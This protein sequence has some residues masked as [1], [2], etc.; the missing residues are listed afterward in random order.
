VNKSVIFASLLIVVTALVAFYFR[1]LLMIDETRYIGVAWEMYRDHFFFV[2][3]LNGFP[4][5]HKTPLLFWLTNILWA[6][7]GTDSIFPRFIPIFFAVGNLVLTYKIY[8]LLWPNDKLGANL[9]PWIVAGSTVYSFFSTLYMFDIM[10]SFWV[11]LAIYAMLLAAFYK[12]KRAYF[13]FAFAITFGILAKGFVVVI[14]LVPIYLL[15]K[16]WAEVNKEFFKRIFL[17]GFLGLIGAMF[18]A[19]PAAIEGGREYALG[20]FWRQYV[21]RAVHSFAHKRPFWW[22][23]PVV[24]SYLFPWFL[25]L[26]FYKGLK[27]IFKNFDKNLLFLTI[28]LFGSFLIFSI[29]SGKQF[30]YLIP[31]IGGFAILIARAFSKAELQNYKAFLFGAFFIAVAIIFLIAPYFIKGYPKLYV[32]NL[33]FYLSSA[34]LFLYG[35]IFLFKRFNNIYNLTVS[36]A[37]SSFLLIFSAHYIAHNYLRVQNLNSFSKTLKSLE[38]KNIT[39]INYGKYRD[40][41][42]YFGRLQKNIIVA[43]SQKELQKLIAKYPK[44]AIII[45]IHRTKKYNKSVVIANTKFRLNDIVVIRAKDYNNLYLKR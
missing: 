1:P 27:E 23:L 38:D 24:I 6:I 3:H 28:W 11:L 32:D 37:L 26:P 31:E 33:A 19:I 13:L 41:F 22:Y 43:H 35:S 2:P 44:S 18:W 16:F 12:E 30:H 39:L 25:L 21:G 34:I 45:H 10:L 5:D 8:K 36:V 4:Y 29:L 40:E 42:H 14:P 9:A 15:A 17:A 20:I 7:F